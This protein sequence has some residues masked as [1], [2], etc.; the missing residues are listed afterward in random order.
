MKKLR[1]KSEIWFAVI[2]II[3]YVVSFSVADSLSPSLG[4]EK[5]VT[6]I[7]SVVMLAAM[8]IF[9]GKNKLS[10]YYGLS[11]GEYKVGKWLL[12][13]PLIAVTSTNFWN[14]LTLSENIIET[15]VCAAAMG[16]AGIIE[17]IIFRGYLFKAMSRDNVK[18]AIIVSSLTFGIGHIVNLLNGAELVPTLLQLCY[19]AAVG[20]MFTV[21]F[22][23]SKSII[24]CAVSHFIVNASSVFALESDMRF[25][26]ISCAV[27]TVI[28]AG[29]GIYLLCAAKTPQQENE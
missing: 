14:G 24:L 9:I 27:I 22:Y 18:S 15:V 13:V 7:W 29:Y 2:S 16:I 4:M 12:F 21:I 5:S 11:K 3:I 23:K 6:L 10:E 17:E 19:A 26:L 28:S 8:L 1:E 25:Q 20:F